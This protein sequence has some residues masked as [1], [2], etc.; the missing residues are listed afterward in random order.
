E[1]RRVEGR[2]PT[3]IIAHTLKGWGLKSAAQ[4]GNHSALPTEE[5]VET[6]RQK[7]GLKGDTLFARFDANSAEG[8]YLQARGEK[9]YGEY[10]AQA[11]LKEKNQKLFS[12][13]LQESGLPKSLN[14]N[15]KMASYPHT[16]WMLG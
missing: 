2:Q 16:Q 3:V 12:K 4:A 13:K 15:L 5:E 9:I 1:S 10:K 6:L 7:Q 8:K 11:A 14:I